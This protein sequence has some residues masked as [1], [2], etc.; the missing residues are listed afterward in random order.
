MVVVSLSQHAGSQA[1]HVRHTR[2]ADRDMAA[3][4]WMKLISRKH[5][6]RLSNGTTTVYE[7]ICTSF[8][9]AFLVSRRA[10]IFPS[11]RGWRKNWVNTLCGYA[12][13]MA[14]ERPDLVYFFPLSTWTQQRLIGWNAWV[15]VNRGVGCR[16]PRLQR[17]LTVDRDRVVFMVSVTQSD[18]S[19]NGWLRWFR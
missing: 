12:D 17:G 18:V 19:W 4:S 14:P 5:T 8:A 2:W 6:S 11:L 15:W 13:K 9:F 16:T 3:H 1:V 7:P 10:F